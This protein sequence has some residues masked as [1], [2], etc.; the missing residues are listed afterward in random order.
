MYVKKKST[1]PVPAGTNQ[2]GEVY[3]ELGTFSAAGTWQDGN[4]PDNHSGAVSR[5]DA[6]HRAEEG[7]G[8]SVGRGDKEVGTPQ[9][10]QSEQDN[11]VAYG[12]IVSYK[13][14]CRHIF[15]KP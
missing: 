7:S 11:G 9:A 14:L 6:D 4:N 1:T 8:D 10:P 5:Q 13:E 15:G 2:Q 12:K 3:P